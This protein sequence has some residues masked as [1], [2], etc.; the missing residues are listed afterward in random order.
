MLEI[1]RG[2]EKHVLALV[3]DD[4]RPT[5]QYRLCA[6]LRDRHIHPLADSDANALATAIDDSDCDSHAHAIHDVRAV[7]EGGSQPDFHVG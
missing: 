6:A 2:R 1:V 4:T 7:D 3:D 5:P